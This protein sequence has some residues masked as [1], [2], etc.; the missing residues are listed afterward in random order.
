MHMQ[1]AGALTKK[2]KE[3][4]MNTNTVYCRCVIYV[5]CTLYY[6]LYVSVATSEAINTQYAYGYALTCVILICST[7]TATLS[8]AFYY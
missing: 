6:K 8:Q 7:G 1:Y 5:Y 4:I 2:V 3:F